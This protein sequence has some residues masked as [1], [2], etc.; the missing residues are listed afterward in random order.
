MLAP[1]GTSPSFRSLALGLLTLRHGVPVFMGKALGN[2]IEILA[3]F[4]NWHRVPGGRKRLR[5]SGFDG[6]LYLNNVN[7]VG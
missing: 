4:Q 7:T 5:A 3:R 2:Y 6:S 1:R